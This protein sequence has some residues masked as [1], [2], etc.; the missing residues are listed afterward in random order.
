MLLALVGLLGSNVVSN[1]NEIPMNKLRMMGLEFNYLVKDLGMIDLW[2]LEIVMTIL[3]TN[4]VT[5]Q[6]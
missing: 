3:L 4:Y 2:L 1:K 5:W 6:H